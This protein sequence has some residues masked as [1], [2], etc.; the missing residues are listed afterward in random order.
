MRK[1]Y[2]GRRRT[3]VFLYVLA[4]LFLLVSCFSC[5]QDAP[6]LPEEG[7]EQTAEQAAEAAEEELA[8][9]EEPEETPELPEK[10][11]E[12]KQPAQESKPAESKPAPK[13]VK[14]EE[15]EPEH[16]PKGEENLEIHMLDVGQGLCVLMI[17]DQ[18]AVLYDGGGRSSSGKVVSYVR[19]VLEEKGI[20]SI[21]YMVSSHYD[22]DHIAGQVGILNT[23]SVESV[24]RGN[25]GSDTKIYSSYIDKLAA[26][27]ANSI[28]P[29]MADSYSFGSCR[30]TVVGPTRE[31]TNDNNRCICMKVF[32]GDFTCLLCGDAE[33]D[34]EA[35]MIAEGVNL[36]AD[37]LFVAHH[38]SANSS[39][40][41]FLEAVS[42]SYALLS[43]G[44]NSY[45]HPAAETMQNLEATGC[46]LWRTD[47][48]GDILCTVGQEVTFSVEACSDFSGIESNIT[49]EAA[50]PAEE[51]GEEISGDAAEIRFICNTKTYKIHR[52]NC[53]S[54]G[55]MKE[56][57]KFYTDLSYTDLLK[58]GYAGC[59]KC[60]PR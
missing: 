55:D 12:P 23:L 26:R 10:E 39:S 32:C 45:G 11:E 25:Y 19:R 52:P 13:P 47:L 58:M 57:N 33:K 20:G 2:S 14:P 5:R 44:E 49:K 6:E 30:M 38:G 43:V 53:S 37:L 51:T 18:E 29:G 3:P 50:A 22:E 36:D 24:I 21:R 27:A 35:D 41:E 1:N 31:Y 16:E 8:P 17:S 7:A 46:Q 48:Q 54:V 4:T 59:K 28:Y 15:T 42:P 60:N 56:E 9:E 40:P 34:A